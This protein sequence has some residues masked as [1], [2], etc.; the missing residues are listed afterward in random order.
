M[1]LPINSSNFLVQHIFIQ[2]YFFSHIYS[3]IGHLI[4][5]V[6][7]NSKGTITLQSKDV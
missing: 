3:S 2:H 6:N 5:E 7:F 4:S 1:I